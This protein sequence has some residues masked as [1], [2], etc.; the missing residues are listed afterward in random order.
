M[1]SA[2]EAT[3][4]F[5]ETSFMVVAMVILA[6]QLLVIVLTCSVACGMVCYCR[7]KFMKGLSQKGEYHSCCES[8]SAPWLRL[9]KCWPCSKG[10]CQSN[11]DKEAGTPA[12]H[13]TTEHHWWGL[14]GGACTARVSIYRKEGKIIHCVHVYWLSI[15]SH[16]NWSTYSIVASC[17][18][19]I[20]S[21]Y[22]HG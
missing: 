14:H 18:Q 6:V 10:S 2:T 11:N 4:Y 8:M 21:L 9:P 16:T 12:H 7:R 3:A 13:S 1:S 19:C 20:V 17:H 15:C 22:M 5:P